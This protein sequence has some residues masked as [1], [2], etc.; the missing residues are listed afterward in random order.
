MENKRRLSDLEVMESGVVDSLLTEGSMR[1]RFLDIG[2]IPGTEVVCVGKSP[3]G[4]PKAF[5]IRG[6]RVAIRGRD[7][8]GIILK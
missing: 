7:V 5:L 1:R 2:L 8:K 4:D 6:T 3:L